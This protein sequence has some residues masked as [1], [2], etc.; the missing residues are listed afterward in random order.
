MACSWCVPSV[1]AGL[2]PQSVPA[3]P[4]QMALAHPLRASV[5]LGVS[6]PR[7]GRGLCLGCARWSR[8]RWDARV[9]RHPWLPVT[10][11]CLLGDPADCP[12]LR[13]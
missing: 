10:L 1:L 4:P 12:I 11:P 2:L 9:L 8:G 5:C 13:V 7:V 6:S 3:W